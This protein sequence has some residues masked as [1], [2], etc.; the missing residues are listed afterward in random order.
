MTKKL[1][2]ISLF[3]VAFSCSKDNDDNN[4]NSSDTPVFKLEEVG[5]LSEQTAVEAK[6]IIYGKWNL[7]SSSSARAACKFV[8]IEFMD[9]S[10]LM[11]LNVSGQPKLVSGSFNVVEGSS[12]KVENIKLNLI[13]NKSETTI[14]NITNMV[15]TKTGDI[16][17]CSFDVKLSLPSGDAYPG[18][19]DALSGKVKAGKEKPVEGTSGASKD[20]NIAKIIGVWN[21]TSLS[22]SEGETLDDFKN[23]I[24]LD[25]ESSDAE[26]S[27]GDVFYDNC[28][29]AKAVKLTISAY[30]TYVLAF[31]HSSGAEMTEGAG[32]WKFTNSDQ[33]KVDI[34]NGPE[35]L[36]MELI[37]ITDSK[38]S[39]KVVHPEGEVET[40][41]ADKI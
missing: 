18:C 9:K 29:P 31:V 4:S 27:T 19:N 38:I 15:V 13:Y 35:T 1:A 12:G 36:K 20:S 17:N 39:F 21:W 7:D 33:T 30:G 41:S 6:I 14:A 8:S 10:F 40:I 23:E 5:D 25:E 28:E 32:S 34:I 3:I 24:C 26:G 16:L 11:T 22:N 37:S 2:L